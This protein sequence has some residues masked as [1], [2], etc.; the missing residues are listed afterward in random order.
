MTVTAPPRPPRPDDPVRHGEFEALVEALIEEARQRAQ[1]RRR[2]NAAVVTFVALVGVAVFAVLGRSAQSQTASP[3][4]S[5]RSSS[6]AQTVPSQIAFIREPPR[7]GYAGVLWVMNPDGSGQ[8][9]LA[10]AFPGMR[11]SPDGQKIT[12]AAIVVQPDRLTSDVYVMNADGSGQ[13]MLTSDP[14]WESGLAWSPDGRKIAFAS[15][16]GN[17]EIHV[18]NADGS[19]QRRLTSD[20]WGGELAWSPT[21]GQDRLRAPPRRQPGDL[22]HE[23]GR[24]R[25]AEADPQHGRRQK[26]RLVARR[27]QD[28]LRKQLAGLR[29]ERRRQRTAKAD[30]QRGAQLRSC[31]V[32]R[33]A[34]DRVRAPARKREIRLV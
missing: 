8:R 10:P 26:P 32:A 20:A 29:H 11:W 15:G 23:P 14:R 18:M 6:A 33:W 2:R 34:E 17:S 12:F 13:E 3:A 30:A 1:R 4:L 28:R 27:P 9:R 25:A 7:A 24:E 5:A 16:L 21:W 31:L 22:R 19:E